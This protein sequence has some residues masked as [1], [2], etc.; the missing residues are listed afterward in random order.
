MDL[1]NMG[2]SPSFANSLGIGKIGESHIAQHFLSKGYAVL[3]I[4]EK[5]ISEGKGPAIFFPDRQV[6][7]TDM[8]VFKQEKVFWI[9][10]NHKTAFT[11]HRITERWVT[12][13]DIKHYEHY[14]E[15]MNR[16]A[17]PVWLIFYHRGGQ[18]KDSPAESPKGLFGNDLK[19]LVN[20]ENH[21]H[22]NW[23]KS[24]M[25]YWAKDKLIFMGA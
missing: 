4:Y 14:Q 19:F 25:V 24:G 22:D 20:N 5:E 9:E 23:G 2:L 8:M 3:P 10:A 11:S 17:W 16:T 15:I 13:I 18:A 7:G 12:G 6:I 21:R 1:A